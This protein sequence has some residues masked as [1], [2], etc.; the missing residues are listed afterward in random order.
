MGILIVFAESLFYIICEIHFACSIK[1]W[2]R[3][4]RGGE[5]RTFMTGDLGWVGFW[6]CSSKEIPPTN[7]FAAI[8]VKSIHI[9]PPHIF[10]KSLDVPISTWTTYIANILSNILAMHM[11]LG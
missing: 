1:T 4:S 8:A 5:F 3:H 9:I 2:I 10:S 6:S 7:L 11:T